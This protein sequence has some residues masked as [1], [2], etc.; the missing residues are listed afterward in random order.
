MNR[1][2]AQIGS[3]IPAQYS[4]QGRMKARIPENCI[5]FSQATEKMS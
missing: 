5:D 4:H 3:R 1:S 2:T